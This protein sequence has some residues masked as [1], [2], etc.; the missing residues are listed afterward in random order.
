MKKT[1]LLISFLILTSSSA[2]SVTRIITVQNFMF[3]PAVT[4]AN[5]GDT[6]KWQWLNG[7]HTTT[8]DGT[9]GSSRPASAPAWNSNMNSGSTTFSYK[10]TV[11]GNYHFVCLPHSP[12]MAGDISVVTGLSNISSSVPENFKLFQNYPNPFNPVTNIKFQIAS[13]GLVKLTIYD[14]VG[15]QI[16]SLVNENMS[17]GSYS[18]DFDASEIPS[19]VYMYRLETAAYSDVKRMMLVK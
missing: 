16:R 8:C 7:S 12:D 15:N 11:V 4:N 18:V 5:V 2:F 6:I 1:F 3:T 17:P 10:V 14:I 19:G 9:N 13:Q